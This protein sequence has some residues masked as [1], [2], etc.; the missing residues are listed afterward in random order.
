MLHQQEPEKHDAEAGLHTVK[1]VRKNSS[2]CTTREICHENNG[3][4]SLTTKGTH[5]LHGLNRTNPEMQSTASASA[6]TLHSERTENDNV[7][8]QAP[9]SKDRVQTHSYNNVTSTPHCSDRADGLNSCSGVVPNSTDVTKKEPDC[10]NEH[11]D[12]VHD[13]AAPAQF[14]NASL[15]ADTFAYQHSTSSGQPQDNTPTEA[16][17]QHCISGTQ[18]GAKPMCDLSN[19][20]N[21]GE[22]PSDKMCCDDQKTDL[23]AEQKS[24]ES[25]I[26]SKNDV[27]IIG[28]PSLSSSLSSVSLNQPIMNFTPSCAAVPATDAIATPNREESVVHFDETLIINE[29][30]CN[31]EEKTIGADNPE[32]LNTNTSEFMNSKL[33]T[34]HSPGAAVNDVTMEDSQH[35]SH[36]KKLSSITRTS[37]LPEPKVCLDAKL[38]EKNKVTETNLSPQRNKVD[39]CN[40]FITPDSDSLAFRNDKSQLISRNDN[41][42]LRQIMK[43]PGHLRRFYVL[44]Q[45]LVEWV[46]IAC[47]LNEQVIQLREKME[48]EQRWFQQR[49]GLKERRIHK[50]SDTVQCLIQELATSTEAFR[51]LDARL[52]RFVARPSWSVRAHTH[53]GVT[54]NARKETVVT[55]PRVQTTPGVEIRTANNNVDVSFSE[56]SSETTAPCGNKLDT[57]C[58]LADAHDTLQAVEDTKCEEQLYEPE[59]TVDVAEMLDES[60]IEYNA[61]PS[62]LRLS[63]PVEQVSDSGFTQEQTIYAPDTPSPPYADAQR[64]IR[65]HRDTSEQDTPAVSLVLDTVYGRQTSSNSVG[66][67]QTGEMDH[68]IKTYLSSSCKRRRMMPESAWPTLCRRTVYPP[69]QYHNPAGRHIPADVKVND[70]HTQRFPVDAAD[71]FPAPSIALS[72]TYPTLN[73][74]NIFNSYTPCSSYNSTFGVRLDTYE[75]DSNPTGFEN[76]QSVQSPRISRPSCV[77][78]FNP[79]PLASMSESR[80]SDLINHWNHYHRRQAQHVSYFLKSRWQVTQLTVVPQR[81][82]LPKGQCRVN[83]FVLIATDVS[84]FHYNQHLKRLPSLDRQ[85][86]LAAVPPIDARL[87]TVDAKAWV[88]LAA[89]RVLL[90]KERTVDRGVWDITA[91]LDDRIRRSMKHS[92]A[93]ERFGTETSGCGDFHGLMENIETEVQRVRAR[94][95]NDIVSTLGSL[96]G[97]VEY[98]RPTKDVIVRSIEYLAVSMRRGRATTVVLCCGIAHLTGSHRPSG[99]QIPHCY[100][101]WKQR[102]HSWSTPRDLKECFSDATSVAMEEKNVEMDA[103]EWI[104]STYLLPSNFIMAPND[105]T[106]VLNGIPLQQFLKLSEIMQEQTE[107][108]IFVDTGGSGTELFSAVSASKSKCQDCRDLG[109]RV[110]ALDA[111]ALVVSHCTPRGGTVSIKLCRTPD[112]SSNEH[113]NPL[114]GV[115]GSLKGYREIDL[116]RVITDIKM[117]CPGLSVQMDLD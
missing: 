51:A 2:D 59:R 115:T 73:D 64:G 111:A 39:G 1:P 93:D 101:S 99:I 82:T 114:N 80:L 87:M 37:C 18:E 107:L 52:K 30:G 27:E 92:T 66:S 97:S 68:L 23:T 49:L 117:S 6:T 60:S 24:M 35:C 94:N 11:E 78:L 47:R 67:D 63:P 17:L 53:D 57:L 44:E 20:K 15:P 69:K 31:D 75:L 79:D 112:L 4:D 13:A 77:T 43:K 55:E 54:N 98:S 71:F 76:V 33:S 58:V 25:Y 65:L 85:A 84:P 89:E 29:T 28:L 106:V 86:V 36:G 83:R 72:G 14:R 102:L 61:L 16:H 22:K 40:I 81:F 88:W 56:T 103:Q 90:K 113:N 96:N 19:G 5:L 116:D 95:S 105:S 100:D 26:V 42:V 48:S 8:D 3:L 21:G 46:A 104:Q 10:L 34:N 50:L 32:E 41:I 12:S 7:I 70:E 62:N 45:L 38:T 9:A 110:V 109:R 74:V 108:N 91:T